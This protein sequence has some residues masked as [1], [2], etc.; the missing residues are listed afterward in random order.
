MLPGACVRPQSL[1]KPGVSFRM[2]LMEPNEN[3]KVYHRTSC[4][5]CGQPLELP[6]ELL[7][8]PVVCPE[9]SRGFVA[10]LAQQLNEG[11]R[12][13]QSPGGTV[14]V[15]KF[16]TTWG[17]LLGTA[18]VIAIVVYWGV[19]NLRQTKELGWSVGAETIS[20]IERSH[21]AKFEAAERA[22]KEKLVSPST[23]QFET[24]AQ[25][26]NDERD[27]RA[28]YLRIQVDSQ[29][30]HGA[31]LRTRWEVRLRHAGGSHDDWVPRDAKQIE[32]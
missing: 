4:P 20:A 19:S 18:C 16:K 15:G 5:A 12:T 11:K 3:H 31:M 9:C 8:K 26:L 2:R 7:G 25:I 30:E 6:S 32:R 28:I 17:S 24:T 22:I 1:D 29:N 21:K 10:P 13:P 14:Q 23:A 27:D